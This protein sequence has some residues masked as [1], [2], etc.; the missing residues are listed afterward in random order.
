MRSVIKEA[1]SHG[2]KILVDQQFE[3]GKQIADAGLIPIIEPEVDIHSIDK[4]ESEK[5]LKLE[6]SKQLSKLDQKTK[7]MLKISIPTKDN[8]YS[9]LMD[10]PHVVRIVALSGGYSQIEANEKLAR[11]HRL[12]ASFS[13]ALSQ[14]LT[15]Q[16]TE[17]EFNATLLNS[18]KGIYEASIK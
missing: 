9:D 10:D 4:E 12:I 16:Q 18:I 15:A 17:E 11:N 13:R 5:L 3:I 1:N 6:I 8:F 7:V 14:G 2:I